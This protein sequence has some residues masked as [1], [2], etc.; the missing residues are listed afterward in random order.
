MAEAGC[1]AERRARRAFSR[2]GMVCASPLWERARGTGA[3]R[4][5]VSEMPR[6]VTDRSDVVDG[7]RT[8]NGLD[9]SETV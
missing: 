9:S 8:L 4:R 7:L 3:E 6:K 2:S 5:D 1:T